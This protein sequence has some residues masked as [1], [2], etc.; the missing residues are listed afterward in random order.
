ML[1]FRPTWLEN[2]Y[3]VDT[4]E[5]EMTGAWTFG[6]LAESLGKDDEK[7]SVL[8]YCGFAKLS[9]VDQD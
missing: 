8:T 9:V 5:P 3:L 6:T 2:T 7:P 1:A 4:S